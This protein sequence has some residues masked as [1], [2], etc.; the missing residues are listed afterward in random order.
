MFLFSVKTQIQVMYRQREFKVAFLITFL[1]ACLS[2]VYALNITAGQELY[3]IKDASQYLCFGGYFPLWHYFQSI[4]PFLIV[5]PFATSYIEDKRNYLLPLY[6]ARTSRSVYFSF[7]LAACF[8]GTA[9]VIFLPFL[10]N[11]VL[12]NLFFPHNNNTWIGA[13]QMHNF[14]GYVLG[15][16]LVYE[17]P[18]QEL[19]FA[20]L[21]LNHRLLYSFIYLAAISLFSGLLGTVILGLSFLFNQSKILLFIPLFAAQHIFQTFDTKALNNAISNGGAYTNLNIL[22]YFIPEFSKGKSPIFLVIV[23]GF[24][25]LFVLISFLFSQREDIRSL[26]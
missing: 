15:S 25:A 6:F 24:L 11:M 2:F 21:F 20:T 14:Q 7:K 10:F 3:S 12:C 22:E 23:L 16:N 19:A 4:Y 18:Y 26:Q 5:L 17:T 1:Y 9:A 13:Y 8:I